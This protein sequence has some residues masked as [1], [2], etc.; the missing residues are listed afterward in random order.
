MS[1][2]RNSKRVLEPLKNAPPNPM[3]TESEGGTTNPQFE[4]GVPSRSLNGEL[5]KSINLNNNY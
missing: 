1:Q 2:N 3:G 5:S 4:G